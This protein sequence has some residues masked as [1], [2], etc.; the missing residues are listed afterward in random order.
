LTFT[1]SEFVLISANR[2]FTKRRAQKTNGGDVVSIEFFGV[3]KHQIVGRLQAKLC[4]FFAL[5]RSL[6]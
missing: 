5:S 2:K 4:T 1:F 6:S 3:A